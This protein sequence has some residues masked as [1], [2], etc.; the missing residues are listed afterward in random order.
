MTGVLEELQ[1]PICMDLLRSAVTLGC[2]HTFC[3]EC[4]RRV[5]GQAGTREYSVTGRVCPL[6]CRPV[7]VVVKS[8]TIENVLRKW[9]E[10]MRCD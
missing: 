7:N 5:R 2:G 8:V 6:C 10:T 1:C 9:R 4:M 3:G